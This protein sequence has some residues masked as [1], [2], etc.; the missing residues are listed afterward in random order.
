[1]ADIDIDVLVVG[2]GPVGLAT[3][4]ECARHA[5]SCLVVERHQGTST[6]PKARLLTTRT[7]ELCRAWGIHAEVEAAGLPRETT[8]A[9]GVGSSLTAD[10]FHREVAPIEAEAPNSPTYAYICSQDHFEVI[11]R[12]LADSSPTNDVRFATTMTKLV[13]SGDGVEALI[14][15]ADGAVSSVR[16]RYAVAADGSRSGV[17]AQLGIATSGPP[18]LGHMVSIMFDAAVL[19]RLGHRRCALYFLRTE[20]PCAVET[21][22]GARR[23]MVQTGY[24][25]AAGGSIDDF[26]PERCVE[27]VRDA[28]GVD[29]LPVDVVGVMPW[30]QQ[31]V[32]ADRFRD[33][34]IFLAGDAAH[35][36]TPQG[37]FG[38]NCGIQDAH[39][40]VWK[41][42]AVVH[43]QARPA[44]LDTYEAERRPIGDRTV[45]ESLNNALLTMEMME[46]EVSMAEAVAAQ[47]RRRRSEGLVLGFCYDSAAVT[48]DGTEPPTVDD[49]YRDYSPTARPGHRAPHLYLDHDGHEVSALD[50]LGPGFTLLTPAGSG[51]AEQELTAR[52]PVAA[53]EV[54]S[55]AWA[56]AYGVGTRGAVLVRPDGHVAWR[57][58]QPPHDA[59][60]LD[61]DLF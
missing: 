22:D 14:E 57:T 56:E 33:G 32:V 15:A 26:T 45:T 31:A 10:D 49:D 25:P 36:S 12:R 43:G 48:D 19:P 24:D 27:L 51:W 39:N 18:P 38:M 46:G 17:R 59:R 29:D 7:M 4:V 28:V 44:L 37:G 13:Q 41:L 11:L 42:A 47:A 34:R 1:M 61:P 53:V 16:A 60:V 50:L 40:L 30:L 35:V 8:L 21:V 54:A 3:A 20:L 5:L 6:F 2:G 55:T 58:S 9:V 52:V 23:W